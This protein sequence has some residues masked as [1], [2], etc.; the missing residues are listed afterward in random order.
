MAP[1]IV[2][3]GAEQGLIVPLI[4]VH[5]FVFYFGIM[6]DATPPVGLASFAAAAISR[7]DPLRTGV[8]AFY[9]SA[10]TVVLPFIF[11][12]NYQLLMIGVE[13]PLQLL[14]VVVSATI[15]MLAFAAGTMNYFY[16]RNRFYESIALLLVA[17]TL[18]RPGF[19]MDMVAPQYVVR[20]A[21]EVMDFVE[22]APPNSFLRIAVAGF[23]PV[24]FEDSLK[25][26]MLNLGP[27][28][29]AQQRLLHA[30]LMVTPMGDSLSIMSVIEGTDA[31][32][33]GIASG[34]EVENLLVPNPDRPPKE[35]FF[36]PAL[37]LLGLVY[38]LQKRRLNAANPLPSRARA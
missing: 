30:G 1:V 31:S 3:L 7:G 27:Q 32:R 26:V 16:T 5:L 22:E 38:L 18:L 20:P 19:W 23:D 28:A 15:A 17:F 14:L 24:T 10:R 21:S 6:A 2:E 25:T 13:G 34:W 33:F 8:Q 37:L 9:Y 36:I 12:F 11:I 4:A 35:L 29:E